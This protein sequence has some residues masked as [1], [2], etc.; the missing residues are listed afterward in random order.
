MGD[1]VETV[2]IKYGQIFNQLSNY[3]RLKNDPAAWLG[4]GA[5]VQSVYAYVFLTV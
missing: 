2:F 5:E 3:C 1:V 4:S